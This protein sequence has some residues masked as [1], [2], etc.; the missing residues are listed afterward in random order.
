MK[1]SSISSLASC[2]R[3]PVGL[4]ALGLL[5]IL[6]AGCA[7]TFHEV[8]TLSSVQPSTQQP[9]VLVLGDVRITDAY[10]SATDKEVYRLKFLDGLES[11]FSKTNIIKSVVLESTNEIPNSIIISGTI[12]EVNKGSEAVRFLVGMGAG[13]ER[14]RGEFE[15]KDAGGQSLIRFAERQSYLGG[16]GIGGGDF[17]SMEELTVRYGEAVAEDITKW[18]HG[19]KLD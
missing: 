19:E 3:W 6:T 5:P 16:A 17:I 7:G 13:Q 11:W 4:L 12:T 9:T 8:R 2:C 14:I 1:T 10:I 18:L 15:I